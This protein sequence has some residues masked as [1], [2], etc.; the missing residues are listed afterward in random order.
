MPKNNP[1]Y[2][3]NYQAARRAAK[4]AGT[5]DTSATDK[6]SGPVVAT[7]LGAGAE[8][9]AERVLHP[10]PAELVVEAGAQDGGAAI[11]P[12]SEKDNG[13]A[14][15]Y[16]RES[17]TGAAKVTES[18]ISAG[19][20]K[21]TA[22]GPKRGAVGAS[23]RE[24]QNGPAPHLAHDHGAGADLTHEDGVQSGPAVRHEDGLGR[25]AKSWAQLVQEADPKVIMR[26]LDKINTKSRS[27]AS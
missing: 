25:G 13:P 11:R 20:A 2:M 7:E 8:E 21:P 14:S 17:T 9:V 4:K 6:K 5:G 27:K 3:R 16:E 10:G 12:G 15:R 24:R 22:R 23:E 26:W 19:P 1:E 18:V